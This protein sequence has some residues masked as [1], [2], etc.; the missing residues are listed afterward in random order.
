MQSLEIC[1]LTPVV[2]S[3]W[4]D[5]WRG[6]DREAARMAVEAARGG[7]IGRF[8]GYF[9]TRTTRQPRWWDVVVSPIRDSAGNPER[10]LALSR[11]VTAQKVSEDAL[12]DA[13]QF[14]HAI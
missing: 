8:T 10:I 6:Q 9:E 11:D 14:N 2:N 1:D 7:G 3:F 12:R 13:M 4:I 5:F